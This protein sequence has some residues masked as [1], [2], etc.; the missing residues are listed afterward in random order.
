ME[1][2]FAPLCAL[3]SRKALL[4][5]YIIKLILVLSFPNSC[6]CNSISPSCGDI[7]NITCPF[8]LKGDQQRCPQNL[9]SK[10]LS[11]WNNRTTIILHR[12][13]LFYVENINYEKL[14]IRLVDPGL[15]KNSYSSLPLNVI[16]QHDYSSSSNH[17]WEHNH[18]L[19]VIQ[20]L[21]P[22]LSKRY[23]AINSPLPT[24][25]SVVLGKRY[26]YAYSYFFVGRLAIS[27]IED[28]CRISMVTWFST[29]SPLSRNLRSSDFREIHDGIVFG[30]DVHWSY[31]SCLNCQ[32][33]W[34]ECIPQ[35]HGWN[36]DV[37]NGCNLS[38]PKSYHPPVTYCELN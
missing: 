10:E 33:E 28:N 6:Y 26:A 14:T 25:T 9:F 31:F 5:Y 1:R 36:C 18:A 17:F 27:E 15:E 3:D 7:G 38:K 35:I 19:R 30:F 8:T 2:R 23:I 34:S 32:L 13:K 29:Q 20:C 11:C 12:H 4:L 21:S 37:D 22:A 16:Q 24:S